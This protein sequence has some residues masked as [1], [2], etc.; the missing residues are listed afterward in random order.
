MVVLGMKEHAL[1]QDDGTSRSAAD[2]GHLEVLQWAL[3]NGCPWNDSSYVR[4]KR[5]RLW[6]NANGYTGSRGV[7]R[8]A[9]ADS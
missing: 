5:V 7:K 2:N 8:R 6:I 9:P 4:N 3:A 1:L